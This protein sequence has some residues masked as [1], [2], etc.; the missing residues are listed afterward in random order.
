MSKDLN[1]NL[2]IAKK[3][4]L[5]AGKFLANYNK[6]NL[7]VLQNTG[8]DIK[9][10]ADKEAEKI[11]LDILQKKSDIPILSE[12]KGFIGKKNDLKWIVDPLDGSFN[13]FRGIPVTCVSIGLCLKEKPL[14]GVIYDFNRNELFFGIAKK[15]AWLN[16][17]KISVSKIRNKK[18]GVIV[19]GFPSKTDFSS[20]SLKNFIGCIQD[21][22]KVR[23]LGSAALSLAY[24][25]CGRADVYFEKKIMFWDVAAGLAILSGAGGK[26]TM[27]KSNIKQAYIIEASNKKII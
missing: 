2:L 15:E 18:D 21:F 5:E 16:G 24:V 23:L 9:I 7:K 26:Y 20:E 22:K 6:R 11:I 8:K 13:F 27:K 3:A 4:A 25:A 10:S 17:K 1:K 12:E 19:V 14:I